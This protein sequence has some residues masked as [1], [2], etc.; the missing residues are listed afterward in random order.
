[1][2]SSKIINW[3]E[4]APK[5]CNIYKMVFIHS[6]SVCCTAFNLCRLKKQPDKK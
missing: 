3:L 5:A 6:A 2:L 4:I 1:M